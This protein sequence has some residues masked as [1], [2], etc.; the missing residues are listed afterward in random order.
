MSRIPLLASL[1]VIAALALAA[2]GGSVSVGGSS[3]SKDEVAKQASA[4]LEKS[5]GQ[6]PPPIDC[7]DDLA[8]EVGKTEIC[9]M[10]GSDGDYNVNVKVTSVDGDNV[11]FDVQV[12][13]Q[14]N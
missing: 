2:C 11:N 9:V 13:D 5:V 10:H 6:T 8:A 7:P 1:V 12:A 4:A 14:K 3:V